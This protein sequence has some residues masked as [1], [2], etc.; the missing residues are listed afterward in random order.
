MAQEEQLSMIP[1]SKVE[2]GIAAVQAAVLVSRLGLRG[3][4]DAFR[5]FRHHRH[6]TIDV[7]ALADKTGSD[8]H[9]QRH[10]V[11]GSMSGSHQRS[12]GGRTVERWW[13]APARGRPRRRHPVLGR[14]ASAQGLLLQASRL[15]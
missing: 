12:V 6:E 8:D 4:R 5:T 11:P 15:Q 3:A 13:R 7:P 1:R 2:A 9:S 14:R 10:T